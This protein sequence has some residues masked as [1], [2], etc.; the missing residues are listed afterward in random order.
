MTTKAKKR[1]DEQRAEGLMRSPCFSVTIGGGMGMSLRD[2]VRG[3]MAE[4]ERRRRYRSEFAVL[5]HRGIV[6][7]TAHSP[8]KGQTGPRSGAH[9]GTSA[10][11]RSLSQHKSP[12]AGIV[13]GSLKDIFDLFRGDIHGLLVAADPFFNNHRQEVVDRANANGYPAI[14]QWCEFVE[15]G[16]LMSY[17]PSL[18][19]CYDQAGAIAAGILAGAIKPPYPIWEPKCPDDF[20]L[21]VSESSARRLGMWPLPEEITSYRNFSFKT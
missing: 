17:G 8:A 16:G 18:S 11:L 2:F 7:R 1:R 13:R 12:K 20:E 6:Q 3:G 21:C 9:L 5:E 15:L 19:Q 4:C 10:A 14:Y